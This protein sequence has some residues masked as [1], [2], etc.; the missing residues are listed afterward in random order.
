M[1]LCVDNRDRGKCRPRPAEVILMTPMEQFL[2]YLYR[3]GKHYLPRFSHPFK[4]E[5]R[6]VPANSLRVQ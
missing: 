6:S 3:K 2:E 4:T 1:A 5:D